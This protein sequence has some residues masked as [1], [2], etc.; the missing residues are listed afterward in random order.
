M[1]KASNCT[2]FHDFF[3]DF[4]TWTTIRPIGTKVL[5]RLHKKRTHY[6]L[7]EMPDDYRKQQESGEI[8]A[9]GPR[10]PKELKAGQIVYCGKFN[11]REI[12]SPD[13][14]PEGEYRVM[15]ADHSPPAPHVPDIYCILEPEGPIETELLRV[16]TDVSKAALP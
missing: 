3:G 9:V 7:I 14:D 12:E 8:I 2:H 16:G 6:G 10:A 4:M 13:H 11:G 1:R 5:V 15:N